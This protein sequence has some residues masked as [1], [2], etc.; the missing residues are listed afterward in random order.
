MYIID[1]LIEVIELQK[2]NKIN[3]EKIQN[4][5]KFLRKNAEII[6][7]N[8]TDKISELISNLDDIYR[9][10]LIPN[11]EILKERGNKFY[12]KYYDTLRYIFYKEMILI[13]V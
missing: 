9:E 2:T 7:N 1:E 5:R 3:I 10:L 11:E 8:Q 6:Q 13:I 12:D 4:I